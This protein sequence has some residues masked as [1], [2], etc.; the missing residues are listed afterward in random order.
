MR[1]HGGGPRKPSS[2][3]FK[4]R[5]ARSQ[6]VVRH[7]NSWCTSRAGEKFSLS[8]AGLLSPRFEEGRERPGS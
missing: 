7:R 1:V 2:Y 3:A 6:C 4:V 5:S 8:K